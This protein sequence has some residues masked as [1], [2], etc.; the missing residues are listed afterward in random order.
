M[1]TLMTIIFTALVSLALCYLLIESRTSD[2]K[3]RLSIISV[4]QDT[5][6]AD[7]VIIKNDVAVIKKQ[8]GKI[9]TLAIGQ[10]EIISILKENHQEDVNNS[11]SIFYYI[12]KMFE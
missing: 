5:I 1:K 6:K 11:N 7:I 2:I 8:T 4:N 9:D 10:R 12:K 3:S